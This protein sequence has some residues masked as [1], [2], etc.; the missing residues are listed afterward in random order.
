MP[1]HGGRTECRRASDEAKDGMTV[2]LCGLEGVRVPCR[3]QPFK[4]RYSLR[5]QMLTARGGGLA[6]DLG[7][8]NIARFLFSA[9][10]T[11]A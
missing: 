9:F 3:R 2:E 4:M 7:T 5:I 10:G 1:Y 6:V 8:T 11:G